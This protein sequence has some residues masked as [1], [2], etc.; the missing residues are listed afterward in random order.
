MRSACLQKFRQV[1]EGLGGD[2]D[3]F[4]CAAGLPEGALDADE[5]LVHDTA[6]ASVLEIAS[7]SLQCPDLGLRVGTAQDLSLLGPLSVAIQNSPSVRDALE[8]TSRYM[9][10]H[11]RDLSV[12]LVEEPDGARGVVGV[13]QTFGPGVRPL[14]QATD[15]TLVFLHRALTFLVGGPYGLRLVDVPHPP[16]APQRAYESAFAGARVRFSR[17]S[18]MLRVPQSLLRRPLGDVDE[19][20]RALALAFLARQESDSE[21]PVTS[22]VRAVL[23]QSLGTGPTDLTDVASVLAMHPRTLQ[24]QLAAEGR[25]F[26]QVLDGVRRARARA[27]LTTTDMPVSQISSLLGFAEQA[28]FTRCARR[29]WDQTPTQMR[30][31]TRRGPLP[32]GGS[33]RG[34]RR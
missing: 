23:A 10:V 22:R 27:Y 15:M 29:W 21:P 24:R 8:C 11:A 2:A 25:S 33:S 34:L 12:T 17:P 3:A 30:R 4:A 7:A 19:T 18:A 6:I 13:Q 9:F 1:V 31:S 26:S 5:L 28:V 32:A 20:V 14:P 16:L